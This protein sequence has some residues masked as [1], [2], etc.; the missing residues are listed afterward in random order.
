MLP[1]RLPLQSRGLLDSNSSCCLSRLNVCAE[2]TSAPLAFETVEAYRLSILENSEGTWIAEL[3]APTQV[4]IHRGLETFAQLVSF[5]PLRGAYGVS[6]EVPLEVNDS[7]FFAHRGLLLDCVRH[8]LPMTAIYRTL[9]AMAMTKMNVLHWHLTDSES[10]PAESLA[11]PEMWRAA[12]SKLEVYTA[13]DI[14]DV[15]SYAEARAIRVVPEIDVP[16]HSKAWAAVFP[17]LFPSQGCPTKWWAMDPSSNETFPVLQE[18]LGDFARRFPGEL[19]HLGGDEVGKSVWNDIRWDCWHGLNRTWLID[20][21]FNSFEEV[22]GH[23]MDE[24]AKIV[25]SEMKRPVVW[26]E[27]WRNTPK[28]PKG[29]IVQI[30]EDPK[31]TPDAIRAG[32]D[33]IFSPTGAWYLDDM[34]VTW[35]QMYVLDPL[36]GVQDVDAAKLLGGETALWTEMIDASTMDSM[37]WPRTAA[38]AERLW[39]GSPPGVLRDRKDRVLRETRQRLACFRCRLLER[40]VGA[41]PLEGIGRNGLKGPSSCLGHRETPLLARQ[42]TQVRKNVGPG[43][44]KRVK[45]KRA[46]LN[47]D[48]L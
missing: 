1:R 6:G 39:R 4:G 43:N 11:K 15:I 13:E 2:D 17:Q 42:A 46:M 32:H 23:F 25:R 20:K 37:L 33:V 48:E 19:F 36:N 30:W 45:R 12:W 3:H 31:F 34:A 28:V 18:V 7:P 8:Y 26:D 10:L 40:G 47:L 35:E 38:V 21:G 41:S 9:D 27:T 14:E 24:A 5:D 22:F 16:G 29:A 44:A